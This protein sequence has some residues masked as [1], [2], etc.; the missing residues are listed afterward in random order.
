MEPLSLIKS[1][2]ESRNERWRAPALSLV[3]SYISHKID[4]VVRQQH[5]RARA[6]GVTL[7][8]TTY[9]HSGSRPHPSFLTV[10]V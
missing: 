6:Y 7:K 8:R 10:D 9:R 5:V 4:G 3:P 2:S 1:A